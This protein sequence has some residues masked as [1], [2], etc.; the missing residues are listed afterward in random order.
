MPAS[1]S[2]RAA[3]IAV[4]PA[5]SIPEQGEDR[6]VKDESS[7]QQS[8]RLAGAS[9]AAPGSPGGELSLHLRVSYVPEAGRKARVKEH[10]VEGIYA[11]AEVDLR[12]VPVAHGEGE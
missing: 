3:A 11:V 1:P 5:P 2:V 9:R 10:R 7:R 12:A 8:R 4:S 6:G